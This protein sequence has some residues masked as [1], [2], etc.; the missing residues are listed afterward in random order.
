MRLKEAGLIFAFNDLN[1]SMQ[2]VNLVIS[3]LY[4]INL[5]R[6]SMK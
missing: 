3:V 2:Q 5:I 4:I 1:R 6:K